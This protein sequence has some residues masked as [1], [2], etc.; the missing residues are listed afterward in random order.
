M[1]K[2]IRYSCVKHYAFCLQ[3]DADSSGDE[4][5]LP[6][7]HFHHVLFVPQWVREPDDRSRQSSGIHSTFTRCTDS[8][9]LYH[10]HK[11]IL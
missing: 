7:T 5:T 3:I 1:T 2:S 8:H 4:I 6:V 10:P 11:T 9:G